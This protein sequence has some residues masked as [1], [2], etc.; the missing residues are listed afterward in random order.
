MITWLMGAWILY[1][2]IA[3]YHLYGGGIAPGVGLEDALHHHIVT[4]DVGSLLGTGGPTF[5]ITYGLIVTFA[6][7]IALYLEMSRI[8]RYGVQRNFSGSPRDLYGSIVLLL[9][10]TIEMFF[11]PVA[12][13]SVFIILFFASIMDVTVHVRYLHYFVRPGRA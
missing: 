7:L 10:T 6:I 5:V 3:L 13:T 12:W 8:V 1:H 9:V 2:A 4:L 11:A